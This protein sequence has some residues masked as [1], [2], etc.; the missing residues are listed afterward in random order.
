M[1]GSGKSTIGKILSAKTGKRFIDIDREVESLEQINIPK[2]F[3]AYG[4]R[5]FRNL[6]SEIINEVCKETGQIIATGGGAVLR[7]ENISTMKKNGIIV[8]IKRD[9]DKLSIRDR[10]LSKDVDSLKKMFAERK[11]IYERN[12]DITIKNDQILSAANE[13]IG[14]IEGL[15]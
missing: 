6:E 14:K 2:I 4:E 8:W 10:P 9:I 7:P 5:H 3:R 13:A 11:D 15:Q 1:P 12:C